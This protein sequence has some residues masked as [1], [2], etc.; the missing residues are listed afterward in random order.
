M[1]LLVMS[2]GFNEKQVALKC[3]S[4]RCVKCTEMIVS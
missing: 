4:L 2:S 3:E 1:V